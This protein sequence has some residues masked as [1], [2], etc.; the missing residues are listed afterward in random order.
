VEAQ[1]GSGPVFDAIEFATRAHAGQY[2]KGTRLPYIIHPLSVARILIEQDLPDP[3]VVAGVLHDTVE[4]TSVTLNQIRD[5]FGSE[6]AV[7]VDA[8]SEA[9]KAASWEDRKRR[10]LATIRSAADEAVW[11]ECADKL[12][13]IR[14]MAADQALEGDRFWDRF[15]SP[16]DK[17]RWYYQSLCEAF[18]LRLESGPVAALYARFAHEVGKVFGTELA[19]D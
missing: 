6:V 14:C 15:N 10:T 12:D 16:K 5:R 19:G 18:A 11:V 9:D 17:Q 7:L 3:V 1:P 2:R 13:N 8:V 4:D